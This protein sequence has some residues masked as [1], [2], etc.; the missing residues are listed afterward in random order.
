MAE[1]RLNLVRGVAVRAAVAAATVVG[2]GGIMSAAWPGSASA[3]VPV[4]AVGWWT[5]SP[6]PPTVPDGGVSVAIGPSGAL[7]VAAI[8]VDIGGGVEG[9]A[10]LSL[11]E[12]SGQG[13]QAAALQACPTTNN[14]SAKSAGAW[15][16]A[17][18]AD[19]RTSVALTRDANG[20][21][22]ADISKLLSGT[23]GS[24]SSETE[25]SVMIV[26]TPAAPGTV[27]GNAPFQLAFKPPTVAGT[28][29]S[30]SESDSS[31]SSSYS[32]ETSSSPSYSGSSDTSS[33]GASS[34][35]AFSSATAFTTPSVSPTDSGTASPPATAAPPSQPAAGSEDSGFKQFKV[36]LGDRAAAASHKATRGTA[37]GLFGLALLVGAVAGLASWANAEGYFA[38]TRLRSLI[39]R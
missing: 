23:V 7:S 28:T 25:M 32:S 4:T 22:T 6:A 27:N 39:S 37:I 38:F 13:Q 18:P 5:Q 2:A 35:S 11:V 36:N 12:D 10:V 3:D 17:P 30:P 21:W 14:W 26:P 31:S 16:D 33:T 34:S 24:D 15:G 20:N 19:C 9:S 29:T 1:N 8:K